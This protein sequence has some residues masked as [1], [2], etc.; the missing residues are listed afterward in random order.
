MKD[1]DQELVGRRALLSNVTVS[2]L[3]GLAAV[4]GAASAQAAEGPAVFQPPRYG[5]DAWM[6]DLA[7]DHRVFVDSSTVEGGASAL[8]FANNIISAHIEDYEGKASDYA[9]VV[10]F[11]HASTPYGFGD[12]IWAKYGEMVNRNE[13]IP[14]PSSNPMNTPNSYS[15]QNTIPDLV[16]RGVHFAICNRATRSLSGR[17]AASTG[18][19]ADEVYAEL[20][21]G[22]IPNSHFVAAGVLAVT[23]AQEYNYSLLYAE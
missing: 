12:A 22:A 11:R 19:S 16:A 7:G 14:T 17:I 13:S 18:V 23:R 15:G 5:K 1:E 21:A 9:M 4:A 8:R 2:T 6:K 3:A 10:C 20:V